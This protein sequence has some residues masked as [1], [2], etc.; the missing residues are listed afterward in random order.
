MMCADA[1]ARAQR[2][3]PD[4]A[5]DPIVYKNN[6]SSEASVY[7]NPSSTETFERS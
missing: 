2:S 7:I 5:D 6:G 1:V 3:L 4:E